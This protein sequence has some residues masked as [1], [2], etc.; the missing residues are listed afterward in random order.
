MN[1]D[2]YVGIAID[3]LTAQNCITR[4]APTQSRQVL[5]LQTFK[6]SPDGIPVKSEQAEYKTVYA[7]D[8]VLK[9]KPEN[10]HDT[11]HS[12]FVLFRGEKIWQY[13]RRFWLF[14]L[15]FYFYRAKFLKLYNLVADFYSEKAQ[16]LLF[17]KLGA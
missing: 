9:D 16:Q 15:K 4:I 6:I 2:K 10:M 8:F 12:L 3:N 13:K 7:L 5:H 14:D 1:I 17:E 11:G